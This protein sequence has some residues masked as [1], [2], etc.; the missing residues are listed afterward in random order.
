[1]LA[2]HDVASDIEINPDK[3]NNTIGMV[4][5]LSIQRPRADMQDW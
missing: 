4:H 3:E 5:D 1:M 2:R